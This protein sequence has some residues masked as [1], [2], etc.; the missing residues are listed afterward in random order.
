MSE[1]SGQVRAGCGRRMRALGLAVLAVALLV[2]SV[3]V[4]AGSEGEGIAW[5]DAPA[6]YAV[7]REV[8]DLLVD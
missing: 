4:G 6:G 7:A 3:A 2:W 5:D 1:R 8:D